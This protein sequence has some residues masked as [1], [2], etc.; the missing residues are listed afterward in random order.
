MIDTDQHNIDTY[1]DFQE[2]AQD[3]A[4][5]LNEKCGFAEVMRA[6]QS[7][8]I[9]DDI[10]TKLTAIGQPGA[11]ILDIGAGCSDLAQHILDSTWRL[12]NF[13][14]VVDSPEMLSLLPDSPHL[15]KIPGPFPDCLRTG[16][17]GLGPFDAVLAYSVEQHVFAEG[18]L[19]RLSMLRSSYWTKLGACCWATYPMSACATA[20]WRA[21][22]AK[23]IIRLTIRI[24]LS[25]Q[26][27]STSWLAGKS[28]TV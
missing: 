6:G 11:K 1:V 14:T 13:L 18:N 8:R 10:C 15:T 26:C 16:T 23:P 12:G 5:S 9:F 21:R 22:A 4:L 28:M 19:L 2:K 24:C 17:S 20:S 7:H 25:R 27:V 3:P